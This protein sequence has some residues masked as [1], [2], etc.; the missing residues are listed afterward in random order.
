MQSSLGQLPLKIERGGRQT[1]GV[2]CHYTSS[3]LGWGILELFLTQWDFLL[4]IGPLWHSIG[5]LTYNI[6]NFFPLLVHAVC[7]V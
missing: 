2:K 7:C 5:C 3:N 4:K 1:P 6:N